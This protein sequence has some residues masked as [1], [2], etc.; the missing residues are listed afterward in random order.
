MDDE[1][2]P[3]GLSATGWFTLVV[4]LGFLAVA[5][6]IGVLSW[7]MFGEVEISTFGWIALAGGS[8]ITIA[9]GAGLMTLVFYSSRHGLDR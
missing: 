4:L 9:V 3:E 5:I 2:I 8:L 1:K 6:W 7:R